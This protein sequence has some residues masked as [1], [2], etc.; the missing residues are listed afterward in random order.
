MLILTMQAGIGEQLE[1]LQLA[2]PYATVEPLM[3]QLS[4]AMPQADSAP[5]RPMKLVWNRGFD[6]VKVKASAQW[7]GLQISAGAITR[8]K[9]GDVLMLSPACAA[10]VQVRL[11]DLPKFTGKPGMCGGKWAVQLTNLLPA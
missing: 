7:E 3:R 10:Q 9:Q 2:F 1:L 11:S 6:E 8:M 4:P 5:A